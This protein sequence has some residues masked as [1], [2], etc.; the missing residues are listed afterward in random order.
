[1]GTISVNKLGG[2]ALML[3]PAITLIFYFLQP[4]GSFIDAADPAN[5]TETISALVSN[6]ALGK[7]VSVIIPIGLLSMV[8]GLFI[9]QA[10]IRSSGNGDAL[11][12]LAALFVMVGVIGWVIGSGASLAIIGSGLPV[13]QAVPVFG[14]LYSAILGI[15]TV[16]GIMTGIGFLAL[17]LAISSRDDYNK[18]FALIAAVVAVIAIIVTIRGGIDLKQLQTMQLIGGISYIIHTIWTITI[19]LSLIKKA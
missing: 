1:M 13:E 11:S 16:S 10:N 17:A 19:G 9:L 5:A 15:G 4:G 2:L 12:R 7:I 6:A 14:S 3:A 8:Y 18:I